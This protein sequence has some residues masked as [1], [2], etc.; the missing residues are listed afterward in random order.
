MKVVSFFLVLMMSITAVAQHWENNYDIALALAEKTNKPL[1][2]VFAGSD[3]CAPCIK[4]DREIW[5]S[6]VFIKHAEENY[7]MYKADFPRKKKNQLS[8]EL[9]TINSRLA[10]RYNP[11]GYF[12]LVVLL[13]A[14]EQVLGTTSYKNIAPEAYILHLNTFIK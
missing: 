6:E 2:I 7:I 12:P 4:L 3:W 9:S 11:K 1:L 5:T 8:N 10:D 13:D 14:Q